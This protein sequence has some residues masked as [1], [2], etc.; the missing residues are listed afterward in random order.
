MVFQE[1]VADILGQYPQLKCYNHGLATF[2]MPEGVSRE[3]VFQS[4]KDATDLIVEKIPWLADQVVFTPRGDGYSPKVH[5]APWPKDG[6]AHVLLRQRDSTNELPTYEEML[7]A[8]G[9]ASMLDG[10]ILC[11]TPGFPESY[12][13]AIIGPAAPVLMQLNWVTGGVIV[14]FSNQHNFLDGTAI[15]QFILLLSKALNGEEITEKT[16]APSFID[17]QTSIPL[18][19]DDEAQRDHSYLLAKNGPPPIVASADTPP[20]SWAYFRFKKSAIPKVKAVA[21]DP[22]GFDKDV[23]FISTGDAI[24]A[25]YWK[26]LTANRVKNGADPTTSAKF[27]RAI[28]AR[29]AV[30]LTWEYMGQMVY[31]SSIR[32]TYQEIIDLPL[33]TVASRLRKDLNE[34]NTEHSVRSYATFLS[35]IKDKRDV[36]YS[37]PNN[38][39]IDIG[40]SSMAQAKLML[41]FGVLGIPDMIRRPTLGGINGALYFYPPDSPGDVTLL[42]CL[43]DQDMNSMR[44][45]PEWSECIEYIG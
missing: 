31:F 11:P 41:K 2:A 9:P 23:P 6:P 35:K 12:D 43:N 32:L 40:S 7:K 10:K 22:E 30:G 44:N 8:Q 42:A 33:S 14:T 25:F 28:D 34:V 15:F 3:S 39:E 24:S 17:P 45:D 5:T 21:S 37:G 18:Y 19:G 27:S 13:E 20:A 4:F 36:T 26:R 16:L 38:R 1:R 29:S